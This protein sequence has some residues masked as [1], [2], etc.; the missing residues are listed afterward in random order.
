MKFAFW[1]LIA[2]CRLS[3][4]PILFN[5]Q[6]V[7]TFQAQ[8]EYNLVGLDTW[9]GQP[10]SATNQP[11]A[12]QAELAD[13]VTFYVSPTIPN[14]LFIDITNVITSKSSYWNGTAFQNLALSG[15][16]FRL[17]ANLPVDLGIPVFSG[18]YAPLGRC[19]LTAMV[20]KRFLS[21]IRP[22]INSSRL[23]STLTRSKPQMAL[24]TPSALGHM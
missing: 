3:A 24:K 7:G 6:N 10:V 14:Q 1:L 19:F 2:L 4:D 9:N 16:R 23:G 8:G 11:T 21:A 20:P 5:Y 13:T 12:F 22:V 17:F 15:F 18:Q